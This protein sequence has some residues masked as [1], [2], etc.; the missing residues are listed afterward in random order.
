LTRRGAATA[1]VGSSGDE[2][3][4]EGGTGLGP[5][6]ALPVSE[7]EDE[8]ADPDEEEGSQ[9]ENARSESGTG[10]AG[11]SDSGQPTEGEGGDGD[12]HDEL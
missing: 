11:G 9:E 3:E 6:Y 7:E 8:Y 12:G 5:T 10:S 2:G 4:E 1:A